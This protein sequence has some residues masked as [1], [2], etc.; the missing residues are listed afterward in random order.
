MSILLSILPIL[1]LVVLMVGLKMSGDKSALLALA[2]VPRWWRCLP[3][4]IWTASAR[5]RRAI[6]PPMSAG[7]SSK[8]CSKRCSPS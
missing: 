1:L 7:R 3:Y 8:G 6:P 2:A 5:C 4:R